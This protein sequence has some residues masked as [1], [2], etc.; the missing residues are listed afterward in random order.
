MLLKLGSAHKKIN[1]LSKPTL[2]WSQAEQALKVERLNWRRIN[3][4]YKTEGYKYTISYPKSLSKLC[5]EA[6]SAFPPAYRFLKSSFTRSKKAKMI[7]LPNSSSATTKYAE[8]YK[9][10][11]LA[12]YILLTTAFTYMHLNQCLDAHTW[13]A[14]PINATIL[15]V[16]RRQWQFQN[17]PKLQR[18]NRT[19]R[20]TLIS[21]ACPFSTDGR[22]GINI[23]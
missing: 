12:H 15:A 16:G 6:R 19:Y 7:S 11:K 21:R 10:S 20:Y 22:L 18:E 14:C 1:S 4:L 2:V 5:A 8:I 9:P 23:K 3:F 17:G 13:P